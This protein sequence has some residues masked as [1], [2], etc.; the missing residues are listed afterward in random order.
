MR[1]EPFLPGPIL[2]VHVRGSDKAQEMKLF[3][4]EDYLRTAD[5]LRAHALPRAMRVWLSSEEKVRPLQRQ[6]CIVRHMLL[7]ATDLS[8][9]TSRTPLLHYTI[10]YTGLMQPAILPYRSG[11]DSKRSSNTDVL[12][13]LCLACA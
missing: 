9:H 1:G 4:F 10:S 2:R 8:V 3:S 7:R 13:L 12:P 11:H 6:Y 5:A